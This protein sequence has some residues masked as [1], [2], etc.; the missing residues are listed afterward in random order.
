MKQ[1][2]IQSPAKL[3]QF[4]ID[5]L[6][7]LTT[8]AAGALALV[9]VSPMWFSLLFLFAAP[10][11]IRGI[12]VAYQRNEHAE[13]PTM[14]RVL[15]AI[16]KSMALVVLSV[17][18]SGGAFVAIMAAIFVMVMSGGSALRGGELWSVALSA[19]VAA[20]GIATLALVALLWRGRVE[21]RNR[22]ADLGFFFSWFAHGCASLSFMLMMGIINHR[23][24]VGPNFFLLW[25]S[26][27]PVFWGLLGIVMGV[28]SLWR[29]PVFL[30]RLGL[31]LAAPLVL[32]I[33]L[34]VTAFFLLRGFYRAF[35]GAGSTIAL[36]LVVLTHIAAPIV[37]AV[38][39]WRQSI[40][41]QPTVKGDQ[42]HIAKAPQHP[43]DNSTP[44]IAAAIIQSIVGL[45]FVIS[46]VGSMAEAWP[47][48]FIPCLALAS[49]AFLHSYG[50]AK[51]AQW[52]KVLAFVFAALSIMGFI[53]AALAVVNGGWQWR[54]AAP[55]LAGMA[56]VQCA[57]AA[58]IWNAPTRNAGSQAMAFAAVG[59]IGLTLLLDVGGGVWLYREHETQRLR[60]RQIQVSYAGVDEAHRLVEEYCGAIAREDQTQAD[61]L[62]TQL[63]AL[64]E[65]DG[66]RTIRTIRF[67]A[68]AGPYSEQ[69]ALYE[70][71]AR[72]EFAVRS[73]RAAE[74]AHC[75]A[76][77]Q[78]VR[79]FRDASN[80]RELRV[81]AL[82][83]V[84]NQNAKQC[85]SATIAS[86]IHSLDELPRIHEVKVELQNM[87]ENGTPLQQERARIWLERMASGSE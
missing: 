15:Q 84:H 63:T 40:S 56:F 55:W 60:S 64:A 37:G 11:V 41:N 6:L 17:L 8:V 24:F 42:S 21:N 59:I 46:L 82:M 73:N 20:Q 12:V 77:Q 70:L 61:R 49:V 5:L 53:L 1:P 34:Y 13:P 74:H 69:Q 31:G 25:S 68:K 19:S 54:M 23:G 29:R 72:P 78:A 9:R 18:G 80:P 48:F 33:V 51:R 79:V 14:L 32:N 26:W 81:A 71:L 67:R 16:V 50:L 44:A 35:G 10:A 57:V 47:Y 27:L 45:C 58:A 83:V 62:E 22:L 52:A 38:V 7:L 86:V 85:P 36:A 2:Q 3:P 39:G 75:Q 76:A 87:S 30:N 28:A 43:A 4:R 65:N 66:G